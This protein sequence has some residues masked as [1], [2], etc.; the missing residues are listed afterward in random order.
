MNIFFDLDG[1]LWDS[2]DRLYNLFCDLTQ[3][4]LL[5]KEEYW[6]LKR[7]KISNEEILRTRFGFAEDKVSEFSELWLKKIETPEYLAQDKLFPFTKDVLKIIKERGFDIYYVTLRQYA[8]RVLREIEDKGIEAY[9]RRCLVSEAKT[10]KEALIRDAGIW[11]SRDDIFI[12]DTGV[13]VMTGRALG[14]RTVAVLSG[15]RNKEILIEYAPEII[16][17]D[18]STLIDV[19]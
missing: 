3:N 13:D 16:I 5:L 14:I 12:G 19:L 17:D 15:F 7:S 11:L 8:D 9:C 4:Q 18:I 6:T 1:T 2:T 10:T